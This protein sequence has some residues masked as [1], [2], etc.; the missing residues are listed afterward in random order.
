MLSVGLSISFNRF[1]KTAFYTYTHINKLK[2]NPT[3]NTAEH[4]VLVSLC[5]RMCCDKPLTCGEMPGKLVSIYFPQDFDEKGCREQ[6]SEHDEGLRKN[7]PP[8]RATGTRR[9]GR[10]RYNT[11]HG[12]GA[13]K[14]TL[15]G[16]QQWHGGMGWEVAEKKTY[17]KEMGHTGPGEGEETESFGLARIKEFHH[18]NTYT[19]NVYPA[20]VSKRND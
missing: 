16:E 4:P 12:D 7:G 11:E 10:E 8:G 18:R 9:M 14:E 20:G 17:G 6:G 3:N 19:E 2:S 13:E 1:S 15:N 5:N